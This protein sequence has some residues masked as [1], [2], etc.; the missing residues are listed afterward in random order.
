MTS[1]KKVKFTPPLKSE[2]SWLRLSINS[3]ATPIA[4]PDYQMIASSNASPGYQMAASSN[5]SP[6]LSNGI[7]SAFNIHTYKTYFKRKKAKLGREKWIAKICKVQWT[8]IS[9]ARDIQQH[10]K[11]PIGPMTA[12]MIASKQWNEEQKS[13]MSNCGTLGRCKD[14]PNF[15]PDPNQSWNCNRHL[16][17][18]SNQ[19]WPNDPN[20]R[21]ATVEGKQRQQ[22]TEQDW[23]LKVIE[24]EESTK[25]FNSAFFNT[26]I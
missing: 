10:S 16:N 6:D 12:A 14:K 9:L 25:I 4:S 24:I 7:Q 26:Y 3:M 13:V 5:T 11:Y 19:T 2:L 23:K 8:S 22:E 20:R 18:N 1:I 21:P 17:R 15:L